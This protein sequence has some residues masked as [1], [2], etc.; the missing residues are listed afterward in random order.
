MSR[1]DKE[2]SSFPEKKPK[3]YDLVMI[4]Y[5]NDKERIG[6]WTGS[7]WDGGK[8]LPMT[9]RVVAWRKFSNFIEK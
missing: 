8:P 9:R 1:V 2:W 6:W 4:L 5:D 3:L 7:Q